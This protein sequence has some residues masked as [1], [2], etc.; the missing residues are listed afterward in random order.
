MCSSS[1]A[2]PNHRI[3]G[4]LR[5]N[6]VAAFAKTWIA[7]PKPKLTTDQGNLTTE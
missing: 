1:S 4:Q 6:P 7:E 3:L 2:S 5:Y